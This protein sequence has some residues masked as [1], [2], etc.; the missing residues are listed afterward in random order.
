M[1]AIIIMRNVTLVRREHCDQM[2]ILFFIIWLLTTTQ[3]CPKFTRIAKVGLKFCQTQRNPQRFAQ[4]LLKFA[5]VA[6]FRQIWSHWSCER[7]DMPVEAI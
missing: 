5:Q 4:D 7:A 1:R 2:A 6:K 3:I